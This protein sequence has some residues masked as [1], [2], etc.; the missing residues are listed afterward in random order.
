V[1][2]N[3]GTIDVESEPGKGTRF[4]VKIPSVK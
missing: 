1:H 2:M 3:N 4:I